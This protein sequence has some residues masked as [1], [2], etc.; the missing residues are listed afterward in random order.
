MS[1]YTYTKLKEFVKWLVEEGGSKEFTTAQLKQAIAPYFDV[2][3]PQALNAA[4][5]A[6]REVGLIRPNPQKVG[7]WIVEVESDGE[8]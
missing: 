6:L 3:H 7:V 5:R 4:I 8:R 2:A 1:K